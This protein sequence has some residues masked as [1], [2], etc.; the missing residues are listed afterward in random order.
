MRDILSVFSISNAGNLATT[1]SKVLMI[2]KE[3]L[4]VG[5]IGEMV[6]KLK[7][8]SGILCSLKAMGTFAMLWF[9]D[10]EDGDS[11]VAFD[12]GACGSHRSLCEEV[13][14]C[15]DPEGGLS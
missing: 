2:G 11:V 14:L 9:S 4:L 13:D 10:R 6:S 8:K 1:S 7:S 3:W 15:V 12:S 5:G